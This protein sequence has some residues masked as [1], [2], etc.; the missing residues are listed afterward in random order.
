MSQENQIL[1]YLKT[2][3]S[4]TPLDALKLFGCFRL[5]ARIWDLKKKGYHIEEVDTHINGKTFARYYLATEQEEA[6]ANNNQAQETAI[7]YKA[8]GKQLA[9][10]QGVSSGIYSY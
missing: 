1:E 10:V 4:I 5:G 8:I 6:I 7:N 9:F 2:G 3:K